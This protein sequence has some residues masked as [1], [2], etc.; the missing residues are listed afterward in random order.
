[1][2]AQQPVH[3]QVDPLI[4]ITPVATLDLVARDDCPPE[5]ELPTD[6]TRLFS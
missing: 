2:L 4:S 6:R 5:R 3:L 1:M